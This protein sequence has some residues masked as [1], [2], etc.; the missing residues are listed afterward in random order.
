VYG[1]R[2]MQFPLYEQAALNRFGHLWIMATL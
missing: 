1:T 2:K